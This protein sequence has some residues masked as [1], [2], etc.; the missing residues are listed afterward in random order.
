VQGDGAEALPPERDRGLGG[1]GPTGIGLDVLVRSGAVWRKLN[2]KSPIYPDN[3]LA[4]RQ[5][6]LESSC[7][8]AGDQ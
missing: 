6:I 1:T 5:A 8:D 3:E 2:G 7:A 4:I